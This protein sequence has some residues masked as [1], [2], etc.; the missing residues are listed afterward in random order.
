LTTRLT[1]KSLLGSCGPSPTRSSTSPPSLHCWCTPSPFPPDSPV[2]ESLEEASIRLYPSHPKRRRFACIRV[3]PT[4][5]RGLRVRCLGGPCT[6]T[7]MLLTNNGSCAPSA[8]ELRVCCG[9]ASGI[10]H[11]LHRIFADSTRR[12][13]RSHVSRQ[14]PRTRLAAAVVTWAA[15]APWILWRG[16]SALPCA[17]ACDSVRYCSRS[18]EIV[19][20][21]SILR[22][23]LDL[24]RVQGIRVLRSGCWSNQNCCK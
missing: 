15:A 6:C 3:T 4:G 2:S 9:A 8:A 20:Y 23:D 12:M 21:C 19:R 5:C 10:L 1:H 13:R 17:G 16:S 18:F 24:V 11:I 22:R 7:S 14:G